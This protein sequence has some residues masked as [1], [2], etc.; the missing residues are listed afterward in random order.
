ML[1]A[2]SAQGKGISKCLE[3][4]LHKERV[5]KIPLKLLITVNLKVIKNK[6]GV[7]CVWSGVDP[8]LL[9]RTLKIKPLLF[10]LNF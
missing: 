1:G 3:L 8:I 4:F 5:V 10:S 7:H 9:N 6:P 2:D